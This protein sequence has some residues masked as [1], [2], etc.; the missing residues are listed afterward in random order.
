MDYKSRLLE[1]VNRF[2]EQRIIIA[3]DLILDKSLFG[4]PEKI[5]IEA[6][7]QV[8]K[9]QR[10]EYYPGGS[11]NVF[12][13]ISSLG[14]HSYL[15]G[16]IGNGK[17][18]ERLKKELSK[19]NKDALDGVISTNRQTTLKTRIYG[20]SMHYS[21]QMLRIDHENT[22]EV[23]EK[24]IKKILEK[25][26]K[27]QKINPAKIL[28]FSDYAKGFL[29]PDS[30]RLFIEFCKEYRIKTIVDPKPSVKEPE[31]IKKYVGCFGFKPNEDEAQIISGL[32]LNEKN[33]LRDIAD[34]CMEILRPEGF[35]LITRSEKGNQTRS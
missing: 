11:G 3:G 13:N 5:S 18:G 17:I 27:H 10:I 35:L 32:Y 7:V 31:K 29:N 1:I 19:K 12:A 6:P 8:I 28:I 30:V 34:R 22:S 4:K 26:H 20:E 23:K 9:V 14:G 15:C 16:T 24:I 25:L 2:E 33:T 21:Q